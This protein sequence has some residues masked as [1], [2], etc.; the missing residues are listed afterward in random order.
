MM[1]N[2]SGGAEFWQPL[3]GAIVFGLAFATILTLVVIPCCY[4]FS[5]HRPTLAEGGVFAG[6]VAIAYMAATI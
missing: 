6:F 4:S 3:T 2:I 5:Y 1:L